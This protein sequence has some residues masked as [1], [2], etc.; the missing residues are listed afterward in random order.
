MSVPGP[1]PPICRPA[2]PERQLVD[3]TIHRLGQPPM[4]IEAALDN[5]F[6]EIKQLIAVRG[7]PR[8]AVAR[9]HRPRVV[10]LVTSSSRGY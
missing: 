7:L 8:H 10:H 3:V 5:T 4:W 1:P 6:A 2:V 9:K